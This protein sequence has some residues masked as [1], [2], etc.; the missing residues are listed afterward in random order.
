[1][2]TI[3]RTFTVDTAPA[4][5]LAYLADFSN[6]VAWDPGTQSCTRLGDGPIEVGTQWHNVSKIMGVST[7][8]T[9]TLRELTD[10]QVVLVGENDSATSTDHLTVRPAGTGSE[11]TYKAVIEMKGLAKLS[12][13]VMKLVFEKIAGEVVSNLTRELSTS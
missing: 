10:E 12:A 4:P 13:P 2:A 8:L 5:V 6:A 1:M 7:D 11:I 3:T 9:Y